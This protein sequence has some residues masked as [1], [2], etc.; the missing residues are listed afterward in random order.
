MQS[1]C[2]YHIVDNPSSED[3]L[4]IITNLFIKMDFGEEE[5]KKYVKNYLIENR[6]DGIENE[7][8]A[9][10]KI[11]DEKYFEDNFLKA[12]E[13]ESKDFSKKFLYAIKFSLETTNELPFTLN[14]I[15]NYIDFRECV[16]QIKISLIQLFIFVY[17]F[18][19]EENINKISERLD[20]LRNI[21]FLP[22]I[23]YDEDKEYMYI[24]LERDEKEYIRV[25][26]NNPEK[27][28]IKKCKKLFDTLTKS[29][30]HCFIFL[31][32]CIIS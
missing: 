28:E 27:I 5:N 14:D 9:N 19:Q 24:K 26:V 10:E 16:P 11:K 8:E 20:L 29:Q 18:S 32:C 7:N 13:F 12:K 30:K 3:I 21:D 6:I 2:I 4:N 23:D 1:N 31:I 17:H 22:T 25:K 15:K